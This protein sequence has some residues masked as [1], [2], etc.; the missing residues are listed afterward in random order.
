M[1]NSNKKTGLIALVSLA[2]GS[3]FAWWKYRT[4]S[5][6]EKAKIKDAINQTGTRIKETYNDVEDSVKDAINQ[7]GTKI[8]ENYN[9]VEDSVTDSYKKL[10]TEAKK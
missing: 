9:D 6:E 7:T 8:K 3:A 1:K 4:A 2:A 10:K 5:P